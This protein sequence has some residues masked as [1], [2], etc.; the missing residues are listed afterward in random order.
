MEK[1]NSL[2]EDEPIFG[3][4]HEQL[5]KS[6]KEAFEEQSYFRIII[7]RQTIIHINICVY[8]VFLIAR[9]WISKC[10]KKLMSSVYSDSKLLA[11]ANKVSESRCKLSLYNCFL[12][13]ANI[14]FFL[15]SLD[16][17][18][19]SNK[20]VSMHYI[21]HLKMNMKLI[22]LVSSLKHTA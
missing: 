13:S 5:S 22:V 17:G 15:V 8:F 9:L 1:G 21:I 19:V 2:I 20:L 12:V 11:V 7:K 4:F 14:G 3:R 16:I 10:N 18:D 6:S